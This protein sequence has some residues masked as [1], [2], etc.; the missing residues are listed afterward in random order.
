MW[1]A[2]FEATGCLRRTH[3]AGGGLPPL[4]GCHR[5]PRKPCR[6]ET[7]PRIDSK[8]YVMRQ[9]E[10]A[11]RTLV[12]HEPRP[13]RHS[14]Q[15]ARCDRSHR[16]A[17][18]DGLSGTSVGA[19]NARVSRSAVAPAAGG[20]H[21]RPP[22]PAPPPRSFE[23]RKRP[24]R[25][26]EQRKSSPCHRECSSTR[27]RPPRQ[28]LTFAILRQYIRAENRRTTPAPHDISIPEFVTRGEIS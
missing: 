19:P 12:A 24:P 14:T 2:S 4:A 6:S 5:T 15:Q 25:S 10:M 8:L 17:R 13:A 23:R 11:T 9:R 22:T 16:Q 28:R 21:R 7:S 1:P 27:K 3:E 20:D 26:R 18:G